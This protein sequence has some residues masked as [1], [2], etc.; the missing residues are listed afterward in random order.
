MSREAVVVTGLGGFV[1]PEIVT[2]DDLS[3]RLDTS[4]EW[5]RSRTGIGSRRIVAEG[6]ST[7]DIAV[8]AGMRALRSA[9]FPD[10]D[11]V[12]L[13]TTTPDHPCPATAPSVAKRLGLGTVSAFDIS[14]V[15]SGFIYAMEQASAAILS[16][17][18]RSVLV[19]G[20]DTFSSIVDPSDRTTA[21]LFGDGAGAVLL[22][23]GAEGQPGEVSAFE[24]RSDGSDRELILVRAGGSRMPRDG[25]TLDEDRRFSMQGKKVFVKAVRSMVES[26]RSVL[27][28]VGWSPEDVDW[29]V[30]HQ[31]NGRILASVAG[32]LGIA[33][34]RAVVHLDR[35]GNTSAASIPLALADNAPRMK[36]RDNVL[37]TAFGGGSTWG[38]AALT[39]PDIPVIDPQ[40]PREDGEMIL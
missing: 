39:W 3:S 36:E 35:V 7:G 6:T 33:A 15:C 12:I 4:D 26:S 23:A 8:I 34:E 31:A 37:L 10:V 38:A 16:G 24:T 5:I 14:A 21:I 40:S 19:I 1:P 32:A 20:A 27:S 18:R 22:A 30:A 29:L 2:N 13:A 25:E 17:Q 28:D 9:G 11:Q